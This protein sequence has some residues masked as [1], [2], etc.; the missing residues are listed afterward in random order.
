MLCRAWRS[1]GF[2]LLAPSRLRSLE[3]Y[4][5]ELAR[6]P[7]EDVALD[8]GFVVC[9]ESIT[10]CATYEVPDLM[11]MPAWKEPFLLIPAISDPERE[12][13]KLPVSS[14][15]ALADRGL[16]LSADTAACEHGWSLLQD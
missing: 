13:C 6:L 5:S 1:A 16:N 9:G 12:G 2:T 7:V 8:L 10:Y 11:Y 14:T 4:P 3:Q 15:P